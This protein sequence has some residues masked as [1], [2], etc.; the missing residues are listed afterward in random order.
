MHAH[1]VLHRDL[2]TQ[3]VFLTAA[4]D[5]KL[6]DFGLSTCIDNTLGCAMTA[7]GTPGYVAPEIINGA[8]Y[9]QAVDMWSLGVIT[10]IL[11][12]GYPPFYGDTD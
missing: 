11:L 10:Y 3:N 6:G 1:R 7:C 9:D 8:A 12:C 4:G 2:K 5:I